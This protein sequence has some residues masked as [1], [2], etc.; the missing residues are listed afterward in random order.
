MVY[1]FKCMLGGV[2]VERPPAAFALGLHI[3]QMRIFVAQARQYLS[4]FPLKADA[5]DR[6]RHEAVGQ[7]LVYNIET[8]GVDS[9]EIHLHPG[10]GAGESWHKIFG[11]KPNYTLGSPRTAGIW[12]VAPRLVL[13]HHHIYRYLL[14]GIGIDE[15][16][17]IIGICLKIARIHYEIVRLGQS[18]REN[19]FWRLIVVA[20]AVRHAGKQQGVLAGIH[21]VGTVAAHGI[22]GIYLHPRR[23]APR[24][25]PERHT[26]A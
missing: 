10:V 4:A 1:P 9:A 2:P 25:R 26:G 24:R 13:V 14:R 8:I 20:V 21:S 3:T 6:G 7:H 5:L 16:S 12:S 23:R 19:A 15:A 17:E 11:I 22:V 18:R